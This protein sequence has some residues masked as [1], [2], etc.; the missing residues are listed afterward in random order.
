MTLIFQ[1]FPFKIDIFRATHVPV[2]EDQAQHLQHA[3]YL[4]KA[5]NTKFGQ[6]FPA[7]HAMIQD[8]AGSRIKSLR[9]PSKKMSKSDPDPKATI[10]MTD[11]ADAISGKIK[12]AV[13][14]FTS[15]VTF[16]PEERPGV[17]N[18]LGI[19]SLLTNSTIEE[20]CEENSDVDTGKYKLRLADVVV[21]YLNPIRKKVDDLLK[22]PEYLEQILKS[23][24]EKAGE[25]AEKT[26]VEVKSKV[27]LGF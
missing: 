19:H 5:F 8:D 2:G 13:T 6:T 20:I 1:E 25:C 24:A 21:S 15:Q 16:A 18:L 14:D 7:C 17:A 23:G 4:A 9:D 3:Q 26:L 11:S 27:G 12:K 22:H 10:M